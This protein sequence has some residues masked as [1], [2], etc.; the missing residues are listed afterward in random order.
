VSTTPMDASLKRLG[1]A[2]VV[3][4]LGLGIGLGAVRL[5][6]GRW[7]AGRVDVPS[8]KEFS[9]PTTV[10]HADDPAE[11]S[12]ASPATAATPEAALA[13]LL[14]AEQERTPEQGWEVLDARARVRHPTPA[15][16]ARARSGRPVPL[17]FE[18]VGR[19][20]APDGAVDVRAVITN[21]PSLDPFGG[22][23]TAESEVVWRARQEPGGWRVA[24]EP[25]STHLR[26]PSD[27]GATTS[28]RA[29]VDA[30]AS[31][32]DGRAR[33]V[34]AVDPLYGPVDLI[35]MPCRRP[36][37]WS[38][39]TPRALSDS[40]DTFTLQAAFGA[41]VAAWGRVVLVEAAAGPRFFVAVAPVGSQW[42][43]MGVT[44]ANP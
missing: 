31:C 26:L 1:P 33:A 25:E 28:V 16:W 22:L 12:V 18:I 17:S 35:A 4:V 2:A 41:D 36:A 34:Q 30:T 42:K 8:I 37:S 38:V 40:P 3:V 44:A 9:F 39:G 24:A 21:A 11:P 15:S 5:S 14:L 13:A 27:D 19:V 20:T 7:P 43:V 29:W 23:V 10:P 32:D 6:S